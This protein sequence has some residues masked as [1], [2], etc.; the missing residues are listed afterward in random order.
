MTATA[1]SRLP[2]CP[3][4]LNRINAPIIARAMESLGSNLDM[5]VPHVA[6]TDIS[7]T[8]R[9]MPKLSVACRL[10]VAVSIVLSGIR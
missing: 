5:V 4:S 3:V 8:T 10:V 7:F 9:G 1:T 6:E 2:L